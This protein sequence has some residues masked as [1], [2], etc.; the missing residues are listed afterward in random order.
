MLPVQ[1]SWHPYPSFLS[2]FIIQLGR[3]VCFGFSASAFICIALKCP[4]ALTDHFEV[5]QVVF[6]MSTTGHGPAGW[7]S[8]KTMASSDR[9]CQSSVIN[10]HPP[11]LLAC[12]T[13][14]KGQKGGGLSKQ[15]IYM[16]ALPFLSPALHSQMHASSLGVTCIFIRPRVQ[17]KGQSWG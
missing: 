8:G 15:C 11:P 13:P 10:H 7:A 16:E 9:Q 12:N 6:S 5:E 3:V 14:I 17:V 4:C 1:V 2:K